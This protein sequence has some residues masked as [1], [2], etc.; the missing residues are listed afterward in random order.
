MLV[1]FKPILN[2]YIAQP[3]ICSLFSAYEFILNLTL[4]VCIGHKR[5]I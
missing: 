5:N 3:N 1:G 2:F 4:I